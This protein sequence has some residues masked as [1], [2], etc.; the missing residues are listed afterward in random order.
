MTCPMTA[1]SDYL[2]AKSTSIQSFYDYHPLSTFYHA[3]RWSKIPDNTSL[4]VPHEPKHEDECHFVGI[5]GLSSAMCY[6]Q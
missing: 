2:S 6:V 1:W 4:L 5:T 3:L